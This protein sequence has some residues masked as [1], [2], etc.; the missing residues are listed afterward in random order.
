MA[1]LPQV[2]H[3]V[4]R[5]FGLAADTVPPFVAPYFF[6]ARPPSSAAPG[7]AG[8]VRM[9]TGRPAFR[10]RDRPRPPRAGDRPAPW[11]VAAVP[12]G[13]DA[14]GRRRADADVH[15][16]GER[17]LARVLQHDRAG[18]HGRRLHSRSATRPSANA[19]SCATAR[20]PI[21]VPTHDVYSLVE[22]VCELVDGFDEHDPRLSR[23]R[24]GGRTTAAAF[25]PE[26][27]A[28]ALAE[29]FSRRMAPRPR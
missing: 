23:L 17:Q 16:P 26:A 27:T 10:S 3:V 18:G 28:R 19:T 1:V 22:R 20:T 24:A 8:R 5:H 7:P 29:F 25:S 21:V 12:D 15:L 4:E 2:A 11:L 9:D 14:S 6:D 13:A